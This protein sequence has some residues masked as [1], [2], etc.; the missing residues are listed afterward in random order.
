MTIYILFLLLL[1][2]LSEF[3]YN[4][5]MSITNEQLEHLAILSRLELK[6]E[7][8]TQF[9]DQL[10]DI[11]DFVD[12]LQNINTETVEPMHHITGLETVWREDVVQ[13]FGDREELL[14]SAPERQG[15]YI[16]TKPIF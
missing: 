1:A 3:C 5:T 7:E 8:K 10:S 16:K 15:D 4:Y 11:L 2:I 14:D 13:E 12:Q 6:D 9:Q